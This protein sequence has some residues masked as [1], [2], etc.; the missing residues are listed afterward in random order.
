MSDEETV[1]EP[2]RIYTSEEIAASYTAMGH[3]VQVI[4]AVIDGSLF[5]NE[6]ASERRGH[7]QRNVTHLEQMVAQDFWTTEDMS[8]VN[9]AI[10]SGNNY[11]N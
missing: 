10:T 6:D 3:S 5:A 8:A 9:A 7:V 11:L 2:V 1:D 4:N